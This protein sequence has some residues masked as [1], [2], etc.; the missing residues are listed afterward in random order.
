ML[1]RMICLASI[2]NL[3]KI[4]SDYYLDPSGSANHICRLSK[5]ELKVVEDDSGGK[6]IILPNLKKGIEGGVERNHTGGGRECRPSHAR[7]AAR[8]W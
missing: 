5:R 2:E 4:K 6:T 3:K 8:E 1:T 7:T